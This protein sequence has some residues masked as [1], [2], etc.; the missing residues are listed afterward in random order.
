TT[1]AAPAA[2][3]VA[4]D[5]PEADDVAAPADELQPDGQEGQAL[6][7]I[8]QAHART[9]GK[10]PGA[11]V[12]QLGEWVKYFIELNDGGALAPKFKTL[13]P[14]FDATHDWTQADAV[15]LLNDVGA[16]HRIPF[17]NA[18][19]AAAER[20]ILPGDPLPPELKNITWGRRDAS[21]LRVAWYL[22]HEDDRQKQQVEP[23]KNPGIWQLVPSPRT[24][25]LGSVFKSRILVHNSGKE[26]VFFVMPSW[27]QSSTHAAHDDKGTEIKVTATEWTTM[28]SMSMYR[29][30]PGAYLETRAPGIGVGARTDRED[31]ASLRPGAWIHAKEGD[32]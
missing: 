8:W 1:A 32:E 25:Q 5:E 28:A 15:A 19:S 2:S 9:D 18:L 17:S 6:F 3:E 24:Y 27:Q 13:L 22:Q 12:G 4:K 31:W 7:R 23:H 21:G 10:I 29:L 20:V 30:E 16:V 26:P 14:R 11:W